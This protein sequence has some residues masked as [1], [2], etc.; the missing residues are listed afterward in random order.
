MNILRVKRDYR[1]ISFALASAALGVIIMRLIV[2]FAPLPDETY[3]QSLCA[4]LL[5]SL[6]TQLLS[7]LCIPFSIY[8]F[9]GKRTFKGVCEF[10][11]AGKFEPYFLLAIPL[12]V[13]VWLTTLGVSSVWQAILSLTGYNSPT[14]VTPKPE[15][16]VFGFFAV[17]VL[18]TAVLPAV[19]EEFVMRGG[20]L[21]TLK[22]SMGTVGSGV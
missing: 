14:S 19:C 18:L 20:V 3:G 10:S 5:F 9:Y 13:C 11:S 7:F 16:F 2:Y 12:G 21:T 22:K 17:D 6:P 8:K 4:D 15:S 1:A